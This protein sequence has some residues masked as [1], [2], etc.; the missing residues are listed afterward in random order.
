MKDVA[1]QVAD[2]ARKADASATIGLPD[3]RQINVAVEIAAQQETQFKN[4]LG[5]LPG[6]HIPAVS[7]NEKRNP[8]F[9]Q[10]KPD[11]P[12]RAQRFRKI[13]RAPWRR[14]H[15]R[16]HL[17]PAGGEPRFYSRNRGTNE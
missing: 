17:C 1:E 14:R 16:G 12:C 11:Y 2:L 10:E 9:I 7:P 8:R 3:D 5:N 13:I 15:D 6:A 4:A